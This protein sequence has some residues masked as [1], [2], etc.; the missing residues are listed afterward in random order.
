MLL[1]IIKIVIKQKL[2]KENLEEKNIE[3]QQTM[4]FIMGKLIKI[5]RMIDVSTFVLL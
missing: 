4:I 1:F 2:P 5:D 3:N